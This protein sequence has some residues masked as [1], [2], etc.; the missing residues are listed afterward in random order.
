MR[1][2]VMPMLK[3]KFTWLYTVLIVVVEVG[4]CYWLLYPGMDALAKANVGAISTQLMTASSI[5]IFELYAVLMLK[6]KRSLMQYIA[7]A[8]CLLSIAAVCF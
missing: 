2:V 7:F 5:I 1:S 6:E 3:N 8:C 4:A